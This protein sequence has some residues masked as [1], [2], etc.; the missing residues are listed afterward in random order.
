VNWSRALYASYGHPEI[1]VFELDDEIVGAVLWD[2]ADLIQAGERFE[3]GRAY[4]D[5]LPSFEG[6]SFAL[7]EVAVG[8]IPSL[9]GFASWFYKHHEFPVLQYL[10]PDRD[11]RFVW[12]DGAAETIRAAQP[13][14][15]EPPAEDTAPPAMR[16]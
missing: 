12:E 7:E 16:A 1:V 11:G 4:E 9:F 8:W 15:T 13:S 2:L 6:Q 3:P 10:W 14:L 5:V